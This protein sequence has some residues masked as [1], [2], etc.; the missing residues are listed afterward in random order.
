MPTIFMK[1]GRIWLFVGL[2]SWSLWSQAQSDSSEQHEI[3]DPIELQPA[4]RGG[5]NALLKFM[6]AHV[7]YPARVPDGLQGR[8][9]VSVVIDSAGKLSGYKIL[10]IKSSEQAFGTF[11]KQFER[12]ALRVVR[13]MPNWIPAKQYNGKTTPV[14]FTMVVVFSPGNR[15]YKDLLKNS[16]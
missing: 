5:Y 3:S 9:F 2:M 6:A 10:R 7:R 4:F 8:M 14:R 15:Y 1:R 11:L 13:Q 12:E 16:E